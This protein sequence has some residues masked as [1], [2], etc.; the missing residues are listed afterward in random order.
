MYS[1]F[2][3]C[4]PTHLTPIHQS[5]ARLALAGHT[6]ATLP[7]LPEHDS[8]P[9]PHA[10]IP[11]LRRATAPIFYCGARDRVLHYWPCMLCVLDTYAAAHNRCS[12]NAS[13]ERIDTKTFFFL[14]FI[15]F[16]FHCGT[17]T[18]LAREFVVIMNYYFYYDTR[19]DRLRA[20]RERRARGC[21][22]CKT[23]AGIYRRDKRKKKQRSLCIK[24]CSCTTATSS[25][26]PLFPP[27]PI[28]GLDNGSSVAAGSSGTAWP[29]TFLSGF[30]AGTASA[31]TGRSC[32]S[33]SADPV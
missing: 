16:F 14:Y 5:A 33:C 23:A 19:L 32:L 17:D 7:C 21:I 20:G 1:K 26:T 25:S 18:S 13:G 22:H 9:C 27:K 6:I 15:F 8:T 10:T 28:T 4:S 12:S 2:H 30:A 29:D 3:L 11:C 24:I 31:S